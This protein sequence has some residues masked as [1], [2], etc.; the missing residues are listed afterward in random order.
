MEFLDEDARPRFLFQSR[1]ITSSPTDTQTQ[2]KPRN[3][4]FLFLSIS[5]SSLLL[6]FSF[7]YLQTEPIRSLVF[8]VSISLLV[9]PF[10]P[11]HLTGGDILVGQG[12]V[13]EPPEQEPEIVEEKQARKRRSKSIRSEEI[14]KNPIQNV[15]LTNGLSSKGKKVE[16]LARSSENGLVR[17][18]GEKDWNE[19][20]SEILK[21]QMVKN[22]VGK[23]RRWEVIAEAF[24]GRHGVE[25][26]IKKAKEMGEKKIDDSDSYAIFLKNRKRLD[27]R[28]ESGSEGLESDESGQ[29]VGGGL[30]WSTGE[31]IALLNA[32]KSFSKDAAM[33]WEKIAAAVP[34]K[35]KA[36]CMKRVTELK[37]DFRSS[38]AGSES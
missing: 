12:P 7:L 30:G 23:P 17:N 9:G 22:P 36:A 35:S 21:K 5:L 24:N 13:L 4:L 19:E 2:P 15:E 8:W 11:S 38:K 26:V 14:V 1:P 31:D 18:E 10:A 29:E 32:L 37:K 20:D 28:A 34:G 27:T 16:T 3:K 25:S 33:R 6:L